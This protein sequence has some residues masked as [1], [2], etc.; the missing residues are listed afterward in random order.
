VSGGE[1]WPVQAQDLEELLVEVLGSV[2]G[3][4][5]VPAWDEPLGAPPLAGS[6][7]GIDSGRDEEGHGT[8][9]EVRV[10]AV[11]ARL[12][13]GRMFGA[14]N[15]S[16]ED[17]LDAVGELGNIVGGNVKTMLHTHARLSLPSSR[18]QEDP[19]DPGGDGEVRARA[20]V[21]GQVAELV[22]C[23]RESLEGLEWPPV[24]QDDDVMEG[25]R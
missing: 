18:L 1:P 4:E 9:V 13:A 15:P 11:L 19:P 2:F 21:L 25:A 16:P 17:L 20:V 14:A 12:L 6:R 22:V 7:I 10:G 5:A 3:E 23:P 8:V 24:G